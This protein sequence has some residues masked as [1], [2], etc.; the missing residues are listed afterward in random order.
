MGTGG[1]P[2]GGSCLFD[3]QHTSFVLSLAVMLFSV[4]LSPL[5]LRG[6]LISFCCG[7]SVCVS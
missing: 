5:T 7:K 6:R 1:V 3:Q 4:T 2:A